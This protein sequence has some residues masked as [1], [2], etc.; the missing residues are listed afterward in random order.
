MLSIL[1]KGTRLCDGLSRRELMRVGSLTL[2]GLSLP[3]LLKARD[4][5]QPAPVSDKAFGRAKNVIFLYLAGGP[6]QH[7]TFDPKPDAPD[8]IR[9]PFKPISTNVPGIQF[10]E[11]LPRTAAMS[12]KL[13]VCRSMATDDNV[14]SSSGAWVLT[15]YKYR[16]P[17]ARTI[18]PTDWPYV[19]SVVK[20][21]K[22]SEKLPALT[23]VWLPDVMRLNE[24]VTPSGQTAG[25][26][27]PQWNPEVFVGDPAE[28][29]YQI[30][31]LRETDIT[32]IQLERRQSLLSQLEE[33]FRHLDGSVTAYDSFQQQ[34]FDLLTSGKARQAFDISREPEVVRERYG[35]NRW[36]QSVLLARRLVEAG[37]RLVHV[38]WPREPGDNASDNPLWDTHA[39]NADRVEDVL[40]PMFDVGFSALIEDLEQRGLLDDTLVVTVGEFGRTPKINAKGGRDHW[41]SVFSFA[42]AGAG[43]S[44]GQVYGSSDKDGAFPA[45]NR[46]QPGDLTA[47]M[48]HLLGVPHQGHFLDA[49]NRPHRLTDGEPLWQLLGSEP[50]T[51]ERVASTGNVARVPPFDPTRYL[52]QKDFAGD[53][54]LKPVVEPSRPKGWRADPLYSLAREDQFSAT[55]LRD[56][57]EPTAALGFNLGAGAPLEIAQNAKV[58]LAQEVRS[59]YPGSYRLRVRLRAEAS[60]PEFF[61]NVFRQNF[62]CRLVF[63]Q[64]NSQSKFVNESHELASTACEVI[65]VETGT[66]K[67]QT[68]ELSKQFVNPNPGSNFSFGAGLGVAFQIVKSS[69]GILKV[70]AGDRAFVRIAD[71]T[72]EFLGKEVNE[73]VKV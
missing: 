34:A 31:S 12:D 50:A 72:L 43:I 33:R 24:N 32:P 45:S 26:L 6:P 28:P 5:S 60:S 14:H 35:R 38:H 10:C 19:G 18:Q 58:Y 44:G 8:G 54:P 36:G 67:W 22:P 59:P 49:Q 39:Q 48:F 53:D 66:D 55:V 15:G 37:V 65:L 70:A 63:F 56:L 2:G 57:N 7:E 17:N 52:L 61:A 23:S 47:T 20:Q 11:L 3:Q 68:V 51:P 30:E 46:V 40:C 21:L 69:G 62:T 73:N 29:T 27:G 1:N 71:V 64:F 4:I 41:G 42:M 25:F 13:A 16:G 9:G